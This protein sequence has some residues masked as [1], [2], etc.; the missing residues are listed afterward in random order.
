M[1]NRNYVDS[2]L[3]LEILKQEELEE[4]IEKHKKS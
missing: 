4:F 2:C 1:K 3:T